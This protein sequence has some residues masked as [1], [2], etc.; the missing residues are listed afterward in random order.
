[1]SEELK[2]SPENG[3]EPVDNNEWENL[4]K[5]VPFNG[6]RLEQKQADRKEYLDILAEVGSGMEPENNL[7]DN[8]IK[9]VIEAAGED[10]ANKY[11]NQLGEMQAAAKI[12]DAEMIRRKSE[13]AYDD[14]VIKLG[15]LL[16]E[17]SEYRE[18][19]T[20]ARDAAWT[21]AQTAHNF[22]KEE[23]RKAYPNLSDKEASKE[24]FGYESWAVSPQELS[25]AAGGEND[26]KMY[27]GDH[28]EISSKKN[29]DNPERTQIIDRAIELR[30]N[31]HGA[32]YS[33]QLIDE[34]GIFHEGAV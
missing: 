15:K 5:E 6:E 12:I 17:D 16:G 29:P 14:F 8:S 13:A 24:F 27:D 34:V 19:L 4:G 2:I 1:M 33:D 18:R 9:V 10:A 11:K 26:G 28:N 25:V 23:L 21:R 30:S 31:A 3:Q 7:G 20:A 22:A 32:A